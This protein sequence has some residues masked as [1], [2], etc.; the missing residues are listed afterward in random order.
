MKI[1]FNMEKITFSLKKI[2]SVYKCLLLVSVNVYYKLDQN[3]KEIAFLLL[4]LVQSCWEISV[5]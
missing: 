2:F 5:C 3:G 1:P 4:I